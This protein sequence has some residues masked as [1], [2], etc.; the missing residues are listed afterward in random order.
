MASPE[1]VLRSH[2]RPDLSPVQIVG[3]KNR[4]QDEAIA[5]SF[6][7]K[8]EE[9]LDSLACAAQ[10][11]SAAFPQRVERPGGKKGRPRTYSALRE[12]EIC[13]LLKVYR[14]RS[15]PLSRVMR[16]V[17]DKQLLVGHPDWTRRVL[18]RAKRKA[19]MRRRHAKWSKREVGKLLAMAESTPL[20]ALVK[21]LGRSRASIQMKLARVADRKSCAPKNGYSRYEVRR[22]LH[23]GQHRVDS[24]VERDLLKLVDP[25]IGY[26]SL[27][28]FVE[29]Y[30]RELGLAVTPQMRRLLL[31]GRKPKQQ[32]TIAFVLGVELSQVKRW[33]TQHYLR[34]NDRHITA[35]ALERY[36]EAHQAELRQE[37][38]TEQ[39]RRWFHNEFD[40]WQRHA[41][42]ILSQVRLMKDRETF[43]ISDIKAFL[44]VDEAAA[45]RIMNKMGARAKSR[46]SPRGGGSGTATPCVSHARVLEFLEGIEQAQAARAKEQSESQSQ[47]HRLK[48]L[49]KTRQ[50]ACLR[51]IRGNAYFTHAK[52]CRRA[53]AQHRSKFAD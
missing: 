53:A 52:Y 35:E 6:E 20:S 14:L 26:S 15:T 9:L 16:I 32:H 48:H 50:C 8:P 10:P 34:P 18:A 17:L 13:L 39:E 25:A 12:N 51:R 36:C 38:M 47:M 5:V 22:L 42:Q 19:G 7:L 4:G 43:S 3:G 2:P 41:S 37:L 29:K 30:A 40:G 44:S 33:V 23:I 11:A 45:L 1:S 49:F 21:H 46:T 28:M 31:R 24:L 27:K